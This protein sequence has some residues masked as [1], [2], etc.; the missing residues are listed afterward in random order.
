MSPYKS[1]NKIPDN[2]PSCEK[3]YGNVN[4]TCATYINSIQHKLWDYYH[5]LINQRS[6]IDSYEYN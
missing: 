2:I 6:N 5:S 4:R 1:W 3:E